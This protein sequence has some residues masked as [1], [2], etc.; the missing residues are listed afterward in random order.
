[1]SVETWSPGDMRVTM[2]DAA[3][4]QARRELADEQAQGL[5]LAVKPSGCSGYMYVLDYVQDPS[6]DDRRFEIDDGVT[7]F[8]DSKSL[9]I[10]DGTEIDYVREGLNRFFKFRNPNAEGECGCGESFSV[11]Q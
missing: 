1:M 9:P 6:A 10:L 8:V 3:R 2:T 4:E 11:T 5:R 7:L